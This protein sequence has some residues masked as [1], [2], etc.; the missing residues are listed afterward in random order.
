MPSRGDFVFY[1]NESFEIELGIDNLQLN[2]LESIVYAAEDLN[3]K[4]DDGS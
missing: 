4:Y 3:K 1:F 2:M